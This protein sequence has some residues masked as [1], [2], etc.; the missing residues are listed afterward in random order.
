[1]QQFAQAGAG[2]ATA[3]MAAPGAAFADQAGVLQRK[4]DEAVGQG[5]AMLA[6]REAMKV[7]DVSARIPLAVQAQHPLDG[8]HGGAF[9]GDG[10]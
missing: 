2:L 9:R 6:A 10:P 4:L 5:D 1:V 7:A 8:R 3:A